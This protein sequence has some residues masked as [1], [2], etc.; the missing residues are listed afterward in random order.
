MRMLISVKLTIEPAGS[1]SYY[2]IRK[3]KLKP[4]LTAMKKQVKTQFEFSIIPINENN[5]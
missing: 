2:D 4:V 1:C 3:Y 5:M